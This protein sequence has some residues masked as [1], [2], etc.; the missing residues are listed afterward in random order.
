M[1]KESIQKPLCPRD[2]KDYAS[3]I[4]E[5]FIFLK[6]SDK[7]PTM[8]IPCA[9]PMWP[10]PPKQE[11]LD[12]MDRLYPKTD[13]GEERIPIDVFSH[14]DSYGI[15][16]PTPTPGKET[17]ETVEMDEPVRNQNGSFP[18]PTPRGFTCS[19]PEEVEWGEPEEVELEDLIQE[20]DAFE[21]PTDPF[22][23][24]I[25]DCDL[26]TGPKTED[27][28][29]LVKDLLTVIEGNLRINGDVTIVPTE[30]I[31]L[32]QEIL[33]ESTKCISEDCE[34]LTWDS[35]EH[36]SAD[37]LLGDMQETYADRGKVYG[38]S[39]IRAGKVLKALIPEGFKVETEQ[40]F[41]TMAVLGIM[42]HKMCRAFNTQA[43]RAKSIC[44]PPPEHLNLADLGHQDSIHDLAVYTAILEELYIRNR[45]SQ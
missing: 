3:E 42:S 15:H 44:E 33:A 16:R 5:G 26:S 22:E 45:D 37:Q 21:E 12:K 7:Q 4:P 10:A 8:T 39:Y 11:Y 36:P 14:E 31:P 41:A 32:V 43:V 20:A 27:V 9:E 28:K 30:E 18:P 29:E 25:G 24:T 23:A 13:T 6:R 35:P 40:D 1:D 19:D 34:E 2:G 17:M 38:N